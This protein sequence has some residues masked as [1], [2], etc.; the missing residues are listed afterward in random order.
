TP[1]K[2]TPF[3]GAQFVGLGDA[4][5]RTLQDQISTP[6]AAD[7]YWFVAPVTGRVTVTQRALPGSRLDSVLSV[8][9]NGSVPLAGDDDGGGGL[10]SRVQFDVAAGHSYLIKAAGRVYVNASADNPQPVVD[11]DLS[12]GAYELRLVIDDFRDTPDATAPRIVLSPTG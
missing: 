8:L 3:P 4:G 10:D 1:D 12:T 11:A 9:D 5:P 7:A 2:D 6:G